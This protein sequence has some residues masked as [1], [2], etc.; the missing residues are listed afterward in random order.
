M[1]CYIYKVVKIVWSDVKEESGIP[2]PSTIRRI[3]AIRSFSFFA[4]I[5]TIYMES[6]LEEKG[7]IMKENVGYYEQA[8][9]LVDARDDAAWTA[10]V[11]LTDRQCGGVPELMKLYDEKKKVDVADITS[12]NFKEFTEYGGQLADNMKLYRYLSN[13]CLGLEVLGM[14]AGV[15]L[16]TKPIFLIRKH[17]KKK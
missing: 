8:K 9:I 4:Y 10:A 2:L 17:F 1:G 11:K 13:Y 16:L 14:L 12:D 6:I 3:R 15:Y 5:S 7:I